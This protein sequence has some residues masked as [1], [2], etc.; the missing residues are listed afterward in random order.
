MKQIKF[1]DVFEGVPSIHG[2]ILLDDGDVICGCCGGL[3]EAEEKDDVWF[4]IEEYKDWMNLDEAIC[5]DDSLTGE[6]NENTD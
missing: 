4:I 6:L 1:Y 5:G 3:L 2:G